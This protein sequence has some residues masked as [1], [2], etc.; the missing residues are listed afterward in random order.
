MEVARTHKLQNWHL[1]GGGPGL[2]V[3]NA[4][5]TFPRYEDL[6][7]DPYG[8]KDDLL[9]FLDLPP[10]D[11]LDKYI[12]THTAAKGRPGE[13]QEGSQTKPRRRNPLT[14]KNPFG[15]YRNSKVGGL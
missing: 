1:L 10:A 3:I 14:K 2:L 4:Y 6:S 15:L 11:A 9:R 8:V 13:E 5:L 12:Q 7:L